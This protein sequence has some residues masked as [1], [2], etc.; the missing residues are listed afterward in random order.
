MSGSRHSHERDPSSDHERHGHGTTDDGALVSFQERLYLG[1]ASHVWIR[2][3]K[4]PL[5]K[6][7]RTRWVVLVIT[8]LREALCT[9]I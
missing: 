8:V 9:N 7:A 2:V 5:R 4:V 3:D 6:L 1:Q